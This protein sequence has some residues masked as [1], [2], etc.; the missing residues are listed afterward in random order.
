MQAPQSESAEA[1]S[2]GRSQAEHILPSPPSSPRSSSLQHHRDESQESVQDA[3]GKMRMF[4]AF[5]D[6]RSLSAYMD[7]VISEF[8]TVMEARVRNLDE[9]KVRNCTKNILRNRGFAA[10]KQHVWSLG[11]C[12]DV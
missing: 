1:L 6:T 12:Y 10:R 7:E 4:K 5:P 3:P 8:A 9:V 11:G 2:R